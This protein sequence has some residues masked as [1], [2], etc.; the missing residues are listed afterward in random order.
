MT[1]DRRAE[2]LSAAINRLRSSGTHAA[3]VDLA[4]ATAYEAL[5]RQLVDQL[6]EEL[7]K[8]RGRVDG[9]LWA[10]VGAIVLD[11]VLRVMGVG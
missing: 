9:L 3:A 2:R 8:L 10:V 4:P 1:R 11:V 6:G 5:T 7:D